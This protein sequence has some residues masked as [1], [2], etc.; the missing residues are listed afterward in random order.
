MSL[1]SIFKRNPR[2]ARASFP[3]GYVRDRVLKE[4]GF[5]P[6]LADYGFESLTL[7]EVKAATTS[8]WRPWKDGI[9]D[10]DNQAMASWVELM[11]QAYND[12]SRLLQ[13]AAGVMQ[14]DVGGIRH[15]F[16]WWIDIG[17]SV[18]AF[19]QTTGFPLHSSEIKN[20]S[21]L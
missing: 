5:A 4:F 10:C 13:P 8:A 6:R 3:H 7:A 18:F 1:F 2:V 15:A 16:I 14:A 19:D 9:W 12:S 11:E 17:G 21:Q 20:A